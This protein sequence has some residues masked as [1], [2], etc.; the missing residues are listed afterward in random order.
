MN[1]EKPP[2]LPVAVGSHRFSPDSNQSCPLTTAGAAFT[3]PTPN[4]LP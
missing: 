4:P 2:I 3:A 1:A